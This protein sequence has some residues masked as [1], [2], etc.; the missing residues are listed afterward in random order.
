MKKAS[1]ASLATGM[2]FGGLLV[3]FA[4]ALYRGVEWV[5]ASFLYGALWS[6]A[7]LGLVLLLTLLKRRRKDR[8]LFGIGL[9]LA[10][11]TSAVVLVRFIVLRDVL[12]EQ[13]GA[14]LQ[15]T[16]AGFAAAA[17]LAIV[18]FTVTRAVRKIFY[19]EGIP[20]GATWGIA[21]FPLPVF[22]L[23]AMG[24]DDPLPR[25]APEAKPLKGKGTI[26]V[27]V[28][29]L[30]ADALGLYG[31]AD[32]DEAPITPNLDAFARR[33]TVFDDVTAQ[34]S[35]TRPAVA[36][37][38]T[39]R[40]VSGHKTM[41]KSA[42]LPDSLVTLAETMRDA[43]KKT[44]AVVTNY[45]LEAG[46]G[47]AQGFD[48]YRYL[49]PARYLGAPE[50]ANRLAAY[51]VYRLI[52]EKLVTAG[53]E[54]RFFYR[55]GEIVN[56]IGM[57]MLDRMGDEEFF[58]YLHYME[59]HDPYFGE[60]RSFARVAQV[61]P[62]LALRDE[63]LSA[64]R[65]EVRRFDTVFGQLLAAIEAR[66]LMD[67]VDIVVTADHGEEFHDHGG[68][69]HGET[70]YQEQV[71]IPLVAA[72]PSFAP[73]R[74]SDL[75]RQIDIAPTLAKTAGAE[76]PGEWEGRDL[77][78]ASQTLDV[79]LAEENHNGNEL[80]MIRQGSV[81]LIDANPGNPRGLPEQVAFDLENDPDEQKPLAK[82]EVPT[83]NLTS[84]LEAGLRAAAEGGAVAEERELTPEQEAELRA[85]GYV[86]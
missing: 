77:L 25:Q 2:A 1:Y 65:D 24:G 38:L 30:R 10:M 71:H 44:A 64:Y 49:A 79:V 12:E 50:R 54:A 68:W 57:E 82:D 8:P 85:L 35:W 17:L 21:A 84:L 53:R 80:T 67:R 56:A 74:V 5:Y 9:A 7:G 43:G 32:H 36:S 23:L 37:L 14:N 69:W 70:L 33:G 76:V 29:T 55:D 61:N 73:A 26:L 45:N 11:C 81:K 51:N 19:Y 16:G 18:I 58:L 47:F 3:G 15:A 27:V 75:V 4:E 6:A 28:D 62:P 63:M 46:Y 48:E 22:A 86:Q 39:S 41:S 83:K 60:A 20:R 52:R 72:G 34:A 59:P 78:D 42:I 66:G 40:H 13:P 31:A